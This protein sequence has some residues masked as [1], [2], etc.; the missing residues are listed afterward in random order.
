MS[1][2]AP[3]FSAMVLLGFKK[4]NKCWTIEEKNVV[5]P[6]GWKKKFQQ[7]FVRWQ[8]QVLAG[9]ANLESWEKYQNF[10]SAKT[11]SRRKQFPERELNIDKMEATLPPIAPEGGKTA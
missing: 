3:P 1:K 11:E 8:P 10:S 2:E 5:I 4:Q 6:E 7:T 9:S